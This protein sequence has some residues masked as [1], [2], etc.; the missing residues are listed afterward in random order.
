M[1]PFHDERAAD[2]AAAIRLMGPGASY[3]AGGTNLVDLMRETVARPATLID[4][5]GL[6]GTIEERPDG[7][8][9]IGA[10]VKNRGSACGS[11]TIRLTI[12]YPP[13]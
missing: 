4:V 7:G 3:L 1:T 11:S 2:T 12:S 13:G 6:S 9:L 8:L 10:G 5:S